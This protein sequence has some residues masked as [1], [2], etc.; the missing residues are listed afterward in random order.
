MSQPDPG[1][2]RADAE[3]HGKL[4]AKGFRHRS[5][6]R[7]SVGLSMCCI[8]DL[9][10]SSASGDRLLD[11][12]VRSFAGSPDRRLQEVLEAAVRHLHAFVSENAD[13][14]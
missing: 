2:L 3:P 6:I 9:M 10:G 12:V 4:T 5:W 13:V 1:G 14:Q 7:A 11:D 8:L